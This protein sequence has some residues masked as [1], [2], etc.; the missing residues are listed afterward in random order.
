MSIPEE[1]SGKHHCK[2]HLQDL[3][4]RTPWGGSKQDLHKIFSQG[5]VRYHAEAS[6]EFNQELFK[7]VQDLST[8]TCTRSCKGL[9]QHCT[10]LSARSSNKDLYK[11][12]QGPPRGF[13]QDLYKIPAQGIIA[14]IFAP[15][16]EDNVTRSS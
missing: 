11:I 14:K 16:P 6:R 5:P 10:G 7:N 1:L 15:G 2:D 12:M 4:A 8:R 3:N 9:W 13:H